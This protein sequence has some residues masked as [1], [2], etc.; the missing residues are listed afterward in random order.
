MFAGHYLDW[1]RKRIKS[2]IDFY[3]Q[4]FF[5][6]KT[7]LDLGAGYGDLGAVF[8]RLGSEIT[9]VDVRPEHL[10]II[11]KKFPNIRTVN[12]DLDKNWPFAH[13]KFDLTLDLGLMC[14]VKDFESHLRNVCSSTSHLVLE[15]YVV[16]STSDPDK[17]IQ[18]NENRNIY[19]L[20]YNG[21]VKIPTSATIERILTECGMNFKRFDDASLNSGTYVYDW[22]ES[23]TGTADKNKRRLWFVV[24]NDSPIQFK[25]PQNKILKPIEETQSNYTFQYPPNFELSNSDYILDSDIIR[26]KKFVIVIPAFRTEKWCE[27]NIL[28]ALDQNYDKF[29]IIFTDDCSDDNTFTKVSDVVSNHPNK[30]KVSLFKNNIRMGALFNLHKMISSCEDEEIILTLDGDD[31]FPN[32]Q[33]LS[34][35]NYEYTSNDIWMTYGQFANFPDGSPGCAATY[36]SNIVSNNSYRNDVWRASHL[37][38]F[39]AW[40]FK[41]INVEDLMDNGEFYKMTWDMAIMFPMLEMCG[42]RHKFVSDIL[43]IYNL[44]NEINDHK[45]NRELQKNLDATIRNKVRYNALPYPNIAKKKVGLLLIATNKY[46]KFLQDIVKSA[47]QFLLKHEADIT[48]FIF[49]DQ[50]PNIST[51]GK[52]EFIPIKHVN[53]PFA[54]MNR[55]QYFVENKD[56]L[57]Q[58]DYLYYTDVDCLFVDQ[59]NSEIFGDLVGVR[60]CGYMSGGGTFEDDVNSVMWKPHNNF[61]YYFG[62]GFSGGKAY[63]YMQLAQW[64]KEQIDF[65]LSNN[66]MPRFHDETA[67]NRYFLDNIPDVILSPSYHYPQSNLQHYYQIWS[68]KQYKPKL[69]LLDKNHE[70]VRS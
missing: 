44:E 64:C 37:R 32:N 47:D 42:H 9:A 41:S 17:I 23:D 3:T 38:T 28:S 53:F 8:E 31:W 45:V 55:F 13:K 48:Y 52:I 29:R 60:H 69:L 40:L 34:K 61:N 56:L 18:V 4:K 10:K 66:R 51:T 25:D 6:R 26:R 20:S 15:T 30:D 43:Y 22:S 7:V 35:L 5:Y 54:S 63:K 33:V 2:I 70:E 24:R 1:N 14:H 46:N 12:A 50:V 57:L 62:G 49:S 65:E 16:D 21:P 58:Q 27:K 68:G 39:Y 36:P 59:I 19:D 67:L 11:N